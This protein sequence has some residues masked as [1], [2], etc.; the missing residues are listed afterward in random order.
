MILFDKRVKRGDRF[1]LA[2]AW[3][4]FL[5]NAFNAVTLH[6]NLSIWV[7]VF[8]ALV[9]LEADRTARRQQRKALPVKATKE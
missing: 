8:M 2:F 7:T 5:L 6:D 9:V 3:V 4:V 1:F